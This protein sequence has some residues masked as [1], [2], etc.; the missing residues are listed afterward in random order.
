MKFLVAPLNGGKELSGCV[1]TKVDRCGIQSGRSSAT[2]GIQ[3]G[4]TI[5]A[6][7][8]QTGRA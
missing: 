7:G 6:C 4:R 5:A 3:S 8:M 1:L 2:C